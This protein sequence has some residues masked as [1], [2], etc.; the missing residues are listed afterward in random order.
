M[1]KDNVVNYSLDDDAITTQLSNLNNVYAQ[2]EQYNFLIG[3]IENQLN[4]LTYMF[5][6]LKNANL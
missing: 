2:G 5:I 3:V 4:T 6:C 1:L